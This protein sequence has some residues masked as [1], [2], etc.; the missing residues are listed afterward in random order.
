[1]MFEIFWGMYVVE[2]RI[3]S[4]HI[5]GEEAAP[6]ST[7]SAN[8]AIQDDARQTSSRS[9][10][11]NKSSSNRAHSQKSLAVYPTFSVSLLAR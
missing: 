3:D 4:C 7:A 2:L 1:M 10:S 5:L 9:R 6:A 11:K 8:A